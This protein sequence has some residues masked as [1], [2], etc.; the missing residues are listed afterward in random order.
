MP[1]LCC[2]DTTSTYRIIEDLHSDHV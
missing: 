1:V 2:F